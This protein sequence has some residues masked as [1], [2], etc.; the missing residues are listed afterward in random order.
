MIHF[1]FELLLVNVPVVCLSY[2][3]NFFILVVI[4]S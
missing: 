3:V 1:L 2:L 4:L